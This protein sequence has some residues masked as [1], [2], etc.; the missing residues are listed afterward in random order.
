MTGEVVRGV[1]KIR[2]EGSCGV[3]TRGHQIKRS[4]VNLDVASLKTERK[5]AAEPITPRNRHP[6]TIRL[7]EGPGGRGLINFDVL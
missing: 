1:Q 3:T 7:L 2:L 6:G 4:P 5:G